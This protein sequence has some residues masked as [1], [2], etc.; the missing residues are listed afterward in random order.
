MNRDTSSSSL[1]GSPTSSSSSDSPIHAPAPIVPLRATHKSEGGLISDVPSE[2][3]EQDVDRLN[4]QYQIS[5]E[6]FRV[7]ALSSGVHVTDLI[8]AE[9]III[10]FEEQLKAGLQILMDPF[11]IDD[12]RFHKLSVAQLHPNS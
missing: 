12:L 3:S 8:P 11:F 7:F 2:L 4:S 9:G 10:V 6:S 1:G 5:Q